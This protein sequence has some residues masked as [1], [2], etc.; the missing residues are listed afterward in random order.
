M[1]MIMINDDGDD[2]NED[3]G[4]DGDDDDGDDAVDDDG[5]DDGGDDDTGWV[6]MHE[7]TV[8]DFNVSS[9]LVHKA[10]R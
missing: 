9:Y 3:D 4:D 10:H 2:D 5:D 6:T 7:S 8:I 1:M